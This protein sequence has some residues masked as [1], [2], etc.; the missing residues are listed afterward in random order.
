MRARGVPRTDKHPPP[1]VVPTF[2]EDCPSQSHSRGSRCRSAWCDPARASPGCLNHIPL[3]QGHIWYKHDPV[4]KESGLIPAAE[5]QSSNGQGE[6]WCG[7]GRCCPHLAGDRA[8][9]RAVGRRGCPQLH[10]GLGQSEP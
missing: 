8:G 10:A 4:P 5:P 3:E 7:F 6:L 1:H 2:K 9:L